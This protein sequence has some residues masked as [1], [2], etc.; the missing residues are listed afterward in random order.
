MCLNMSS[1]EIQQFNIIKN[2]ARGVGEIC[3]T[4]LLK[5]IVYFSQLIITQKQTIDGRQVHPVQH[6]HMLHLL[7][8]RKCMIFIMNMKMSALIK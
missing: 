4:Q 6:I 8:I 3:T 2:H 5:I 7:K 1:N